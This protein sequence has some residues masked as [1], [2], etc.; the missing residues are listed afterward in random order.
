MVSLEGLDPA[1]H[2]EITGPQTGVGARSAW[3]GNRKAGRG[4]MQIIRDDPDQVEILVVFEK[5]FPSR[6][7]SSFL[8][9][10]AGDATEVEWQMVGEQNRLMRVLSPVL[11]MD[12]LL[13]KDLEK[14][15]AQLKTVAQR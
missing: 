7:T 11:S 8:L 2:R 1:M 3:R 15:L 9:R 5:P 13:G 10:P 14:G 6:S 4:A 12:R